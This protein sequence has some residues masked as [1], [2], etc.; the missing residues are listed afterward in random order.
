[1]AARHQL[2]VR[3]M[4]VR[5]QQKL[6]LLLLLRQPHPPVTLLKQHQEVSSSRGLAP[7]TQTVIQSAVDLNLGSVQ[8]RSSRRN[9]MVDVD[10]ETRRQMTMRRKHSLDG[11]WEG[12]GQIICRVD[13]IA[14]VRV[15]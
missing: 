1:M 12:G 13:Q 6:H 7:Q 8:A 4:E 11:A 3:Q 14:G 2:L 9:E 10:S 5:Q 15:V